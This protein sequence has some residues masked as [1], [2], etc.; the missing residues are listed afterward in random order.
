MPI[1]ALFVLF[2][3]LGASLLAAVRHLHPRPVTVPVRVA[4]RRARR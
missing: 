4:V 2:L 1:V 3:L